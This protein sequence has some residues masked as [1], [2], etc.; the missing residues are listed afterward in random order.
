[1]A[2]LFFD[3]E[4][5][6]RWKGQGKICSF[7]YAIFDEDFH[8]I[9]KKDI[10][11][12]PRAPFDKKILGGAKARMALAYPKESFYAQK[13]FAYLYP[14]IQFLLTEPKMT[15]LGYSLKDD[16]AYLNQECSRYGLTMANFPFIDV[17]TIGQKVTASATP[18]S[19]EKACARYA[20]DTHDLQFHK[21][22]DDAEMSALVLKAI[23]HRLG[24]SLK[25]T[26]A[27]F[28]SAHSNVHAFLTKPRLG[29]RRSHCDRHLTLPPSPN[30]KEKNKELNAMI[31]EKNQVA[32]PGPLGGATYSISYLIKEDI[33]TALRLAKQIKALGGRLEKSLKKSDFII[34]Y[35]E[36]E[37]AF[38]QGRFDCTHLQ[39]ITLKEAQEIFD[40]SKTN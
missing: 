25:D 18:E 24:F 30:A 5:A 38:D 1:M 15:I 9:E 23:S 19:L 26:L 40:K 16:I 34:T 28:P 14:T 35:D 12:N 29:H 20:I 21:S 17:Q 37:Q 10:L 32:L 39:I 3:C 22:C 36:E 8:R 6:N 27:Y 31:E 2:Y 4:C 11:I 7:G 33:D 13:D